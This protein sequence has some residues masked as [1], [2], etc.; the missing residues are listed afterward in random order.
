MKHPLAICPVCKRAYAV[1]AGRMARHF[2]TVP[3]G[4]PGC[5]TR[6]PCPGSRSA[7][8]QVARDDTARAFDRRALEVAADDYG[9]WLK[10]AERDL[11]RAQDT[12]DEY[13]AGLAQAAHAKFDAAH[14]ASKKKA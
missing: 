10:R 1:A 5:V 12:V 3:S 14:P 11:K 8:T 7:V 13:R 2:S 6:G 4:T 9:R